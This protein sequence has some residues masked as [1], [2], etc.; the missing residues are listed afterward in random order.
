MPRRLFIAL[1]IA[2]LGTGHAG[3]LEDMLR[4]ATENALRQATSPASP[5]P[6]PAPAPS[7][8]PNP[9]AWPVSDA[10]RSYVAPQATER[11]V[12]VPLRMSLDATYGRK[13]TNQPDRPQVTLS[14][15][16]LDPAKLVL[17]EPQALQCSADG[18][19]VIGAQ[20]GIDTSLRTVGIGYWR[21]APDG[22]V[23]PW[24]TRSTKAYGKTGRTI[25]D[26]PYGKTRMGTPR[27]VLQADGSLVGAVFGGLVRVHGDGQVQRLAGSPRLCE[28]DGA[29]G[30]D[31]FAD[32]P[33]DA[34]RFKDIGA[35]V[36]GAEGRLWVVDQGGCA[37]R[38]VDPDG[39]VQTVAGPD[40]LCAKDTPAADRI[41]LQHLAW[42]PI[43]GEL[44]AA[45]NFLSSS[46]LVTTVWRIKPDGQARRVLLGHKVGKSPAGDRLDG[47]YALALDPQGRIHIGSRRMGHDH[48]GVLRVD[49]AR[50]TVVP[51]T[52]AALPAGASLREHPIDGPA[53]R[54]RFVKLREMCFVPDGTLYL[55]DEI[56]VRRLDR[57]G[58]VTTWA[59]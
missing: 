32:G 18:A 35:V 56:L 47:I 19:V 44:V 11:V 29:A 54:A 49:E 42:D 8:V 59:F 14:N 40:R 3:P 50:G 22:A 1:L 46:Q 30:I 27:P 26:A 9:A 52:G 37:L 41:P 45:G 34:A 13:F 51:V 25:C 58:Q 23:T 20:A 6:A 5:T 38:R 12:Q 7:P 36:A 31:G 53:D 39:Q 4:R 48:L 10:E 24:H 16:Y 2:T 28:P 43:Q 57:A 21:I 15:P 33:A 55:L 17:A